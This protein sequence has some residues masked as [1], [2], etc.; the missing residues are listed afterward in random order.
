MQHMQGLA[1]TLRCWS[2]LT[3][4]IVLCCALQGSFQLFCVIGQERLVKVKAGEYYPVAPKWEAAPGVALG[5]DVPTE[6]LSCA[7]GVPHSHSLPTGRPLQFW[8]T[9]SK[10]PAWLLQQSCE[11]SCRSSDYTD[12]DLEAMNFGGTVSSHLFDHNKSWW[13]CVPEVNKRL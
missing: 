3:P 1:H 6:Q 5:L 7:H 10:I 12:T 2:L 13:E 11:C 4:G 9:T 8:H